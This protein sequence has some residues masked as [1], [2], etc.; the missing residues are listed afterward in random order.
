MT[1]PTTEAN[2]NKKQ[3]LDSIDHWDQ[4]PLYRRSGSPR[5]IM[6]RNMPISIAPK[7]VS[8]PESEA[9]PSSQSVVHT[10]DFSSI[11]RVSVVS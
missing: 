2:N 4:R 9:M 3:V 7:G 1:S 10:S 11:L 6:A 8:C 5:Q